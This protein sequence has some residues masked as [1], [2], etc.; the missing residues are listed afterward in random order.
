MTGFLLCSDGVHGALAAET[1]AQI[2]C[3][4]S[5]PEDTARALVAAAL[6]R[7]A[8]DNCTALVLDVVELPATTAGG[9]QCVDRRGCRSLPTPNQGQTVDGFALKALVSDGRFTRLFG[10]RTTVR[11]AMWC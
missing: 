3:R 7:S 10:P 6:E 8:Q 5:A 1:I 4:R 2:L 11:W 9:Y